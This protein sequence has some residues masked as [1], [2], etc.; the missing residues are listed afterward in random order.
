MQAF[1]GAEE[2]RARLVGLIADGDYRVEWLVEVAIERLALLAGDIDSEL[3]HCINRK[4]THV[5]SFGARRE[6]FEPIPA[7]RAQ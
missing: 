1:S 6:C 5:R 4:W 3:T 7:Q 2:H